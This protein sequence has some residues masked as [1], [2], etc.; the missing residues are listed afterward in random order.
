MTLAK[1]DKKGSGVGVEIMN[2]G[3]QRHHHSMFNVG[4]SM[5]DLPAMP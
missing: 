1:G 5:F 4:C 3:A 2:S